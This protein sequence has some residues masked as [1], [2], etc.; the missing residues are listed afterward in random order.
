MAGDC[1]YVVAALWLA[2]GVAWHIAALFVRVVSGSVSAAWGSIRFRPLTCTY[3][4]CGPA[5]RAD[6]L[7]KSYPPENIYALFRGT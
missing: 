7:M 5:V 1:S 4:P 3:A 6:E 2:V